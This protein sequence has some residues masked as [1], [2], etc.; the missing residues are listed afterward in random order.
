M[1]YYNAVAY[2]RGLQAVVDRCQIEA[3]N[4]KLISWPVYLE[5]ERI[6][7]DSSLIFM[8]FATNLPRWR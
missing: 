3:I 6:N 4:I 7:K 8:C 5:R 1:D 2:R